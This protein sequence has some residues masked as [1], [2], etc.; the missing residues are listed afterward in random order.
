MIPDTA[1][2]PAQATTAEGPRPCAETAGPAVGKWLGNKGRC[3][4]LDSSCE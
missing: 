2:G 1:G 3:G 4:V